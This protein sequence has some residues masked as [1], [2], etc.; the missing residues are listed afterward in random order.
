MCGINTKY[1]KLKFCSI[2]SACRK[3]LD[4]E[5]VRFRILDDFVKPCNGRFNVEKA[6]NEYEFCRDAQRLLHCVISFSTWGSEST[7]LVND[8]HRLVNAYKFL[9]P[10]T[11]NLET[12]YTRYLSEFSFPVENNTVDLVSTESNSGTTENNEEPTIV[13]HIQFVGMYNTI[14][15]NNVP[16]LLK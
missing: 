7:C 3:I 9:A 16:S 10:P 12:C 14:N 2:K 11:F 15:Q 5:R 8:K 4:A 6:T 13:N 1:E